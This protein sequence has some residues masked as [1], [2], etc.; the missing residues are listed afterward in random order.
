VRHH[1]LVT[2]D[3]V[4]ERLVAIARQ[5]GGVVTARD[6]EDDDDLAAHQDLVSAAGHA[7]AGSTNVLATS[8]DTGWFPYA[9]LRFTELP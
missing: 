1:G 3:D 6:V 5:K 2:Y 8:S 4:V 9:E 7:L